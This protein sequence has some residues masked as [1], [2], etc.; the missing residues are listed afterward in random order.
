MLSDDFDEMEQQALRIAS[1]GDNVNVKIP[2]TTTNGEPTGI[3][4]RRL[5]NEGVKLNVTA[6]LTLGQVRAV[7][8]YLDG[9]PASIVSVFAGRIA[10]TGHDPIPIMSAALELVRSFDNIELLWAAPARS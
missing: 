8:E 3:L 6:L 2:V 9:G 5:A 1:W 4:I 7:T 10:D